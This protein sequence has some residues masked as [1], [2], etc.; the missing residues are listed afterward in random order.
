MT[1]PQDLDDA[2]SD[3]DSDVRPTKQILFGM[4]VPYIRT[5]MGRVIIGY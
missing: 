2:D 1:K 4:V 3:D 5:E